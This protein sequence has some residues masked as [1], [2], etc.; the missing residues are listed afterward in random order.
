MYFYIFHN[1]I[2]SDALQGLGL[3]CFDVKCHYF[4]FYNVEYVYNDV[5]LNMFITII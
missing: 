3:K 2:I 4:N 5:V 1:S